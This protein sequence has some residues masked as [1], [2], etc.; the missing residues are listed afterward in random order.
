[1]AARADPLGM[2]IAVIHGP[3]LNALGTR[4]PQTYGTTTLRD[5]DE[6]VAQEAGALGMSVTCAQY[7]GE[8]DI[9]DALHEAGARCAGVV[10]NPGAY[11]HYSYAVRDAIAAIPIP[12]VEVHISNIH[13]REA[14]RRTSVTAEACAGSIA[15]FGA[16]SYVLALRALRLITSGP[17]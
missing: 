11:T 5:I 8:G 3:N 4:E 12:V 7:N 6:L 17:R 15:G 2:D 1:M 9:V 16:F 13:A 14:F 10:L